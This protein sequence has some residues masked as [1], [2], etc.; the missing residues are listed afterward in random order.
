MLEQSVTLKLAGAPAAK[1]GVELIA[2]KN[3]SAIAVNANAAF[4]F[5]GFMPALDAGMFPQIIELTVSCIFI[6]AAFSSK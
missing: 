5:R 1:A 3:T 6:R 4:L 2:R